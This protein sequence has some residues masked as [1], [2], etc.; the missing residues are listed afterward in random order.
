VK[1]DRE[2]ANDLHRYLMFRANQEGV[3][4]GFNPEF[5]LYALREGITEFFGINVH[6]GAIQADQQNLEAFAKW[7][8]LN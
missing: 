1:T 7:A 2:I 6:N 3:K 4:Y 5:F 8:S